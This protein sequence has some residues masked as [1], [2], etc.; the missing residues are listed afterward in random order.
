MAPRNLTYLV[1]KPDT[2]TVSIEFNAPGRGA[3]GKH[4]ITLLGDHLLQLSEQRVPPVVASDFQRKPLQP[5]EAY[6]EDRSYR[7]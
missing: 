5:P 2:Q 6:Q 1:Y 3:I 4:S 7:H